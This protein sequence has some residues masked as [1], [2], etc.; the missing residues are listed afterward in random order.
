MTVLVER[1]IQITVDGAVDAWK[2]DDDDR[3][4]LSHCMKAVDFIV[5]FADFYMFIEVKDPQHPNAREANQAATVQSFQSGE[6][7]RDFLHKYRDSF[8][9]EWASGRAHKPIYYFILFAWDGLDSA[10]LHRRTVALQRNLPVGRTV[11]SWRNP[12][13]HGCGVFNIDTWNRNLPQYP[14]TRLP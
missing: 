11:A 6:M 9:Y 8:L 4:L 3:H 1:N 13:A 14:I 10:A 7:D 2:F 12:I 5:E